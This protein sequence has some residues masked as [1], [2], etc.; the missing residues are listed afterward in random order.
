MDAERP[1]TTV[2]SQPSKAI[3]ID[4]D[5]PSILSISIVAAIVSDVLHE[6]V[7]HGLTALLTGAPSGLLTTVAWSSQFDSR[8]VEAGGTLVNLAAG[9]VLW[10]L[11]RACRHGSV[12][13]RYFLLICCA[14]NWL[15]GTGY[16]LFSGVS[17]FGDWALVIR[18]LQPH[19]AWR[20]C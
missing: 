6:G 19:W 8:L 12:S 7:G 11:L 2:T 10:L 3:P 17:D 14:F 1:T 15:S 4:D 16:F 5:V 13:W 20:S 9:L 18:G